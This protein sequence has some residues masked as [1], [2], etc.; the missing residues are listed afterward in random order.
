MP[1]EIISGDPSEEALS[2]TEKI[3]EQER[4]RIARDL[5]DELG[6]HLT[7]IKMALG[8][9]R[10]SLAQAA[11]MEKQHDQAHYAEEL[12]DEAGDAMHGII[13]DLCPPIVEFGLAEALEWQSRMFTRQTGIVCRQRC[14]DGLE[15]L[16]EFEV[17]TLFRIVREAL[18]NVAKYAQADNALITAGRE[19]DVLS[20]RIEDDGCGFDPSA[21]LRSGHGLGNMRRRAQALGATLQLDSAPGKGTVIRVEIPVAR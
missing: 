14:G 9:L 6:A 10:E 4:A 7:G 21:A 12:V 20:L 17:I 11:G 5:H 8:Q 18:N 1:Q 2:L 3:R 19:G 15:G 13:D 16:E